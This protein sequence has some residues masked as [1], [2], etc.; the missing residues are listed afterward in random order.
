MNKAPG[1]SVLESCKPCARDVTAK[2][3][4]DGKT[5]ERNERWKPPGATL[6]AQTQD[7]VFPTQCITGICQGPNVCLEPRP[8]AVGSKAGFG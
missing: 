3:S 2:E 5:S 4:G 8:K 1:A 7:S 6:G